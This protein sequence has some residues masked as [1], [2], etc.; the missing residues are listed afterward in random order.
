MA[1]RFLLCSAAAVIA[2]AL[3]C[4][5]SA[6][7]PASPSS[8]T[9][10]VSDAAADGSTLKATAPA[11]VSPIN[12]AQPETLELTANKSIGKFDSSVVLSYEFEIKNAGGTVVCNSGVI[13]GGT[14]ATVSY[15]PTCSLEFDAEHTWRA[16]AVYA[17][18][19][20]PWSA[21]ASF[22]TPTG[23]Y[24]NGNE[25]F[26]PL[27]NGKTVG[28]IRGPVQ[29]V[30]GVGAKLVGHESHILYRIPV[31]L[32]AG[33]FS[34][35]ILG[36]DEGTEGD[37]SKVFSMQEGPDENDITDDD[38]RFTAEL[39]G[40][41]YAQPGS[42]TYRIICGD[43]VSRDG[44]RNQLNFDSSRWYFWKFT[45]RTGSATL[46]VRRDSET[47]SV[48]YSST[49]GTGSHPYRPDPHYLYLGAPVGRAGLMDATLPGGT[50]KNVWASSRPRPSFPN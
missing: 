12:G 18:A 9:P 23:G 5:K 7:N 49:V 44:A 8:T 27:T 34:M 39:R 43:A 15:T 45:W 32:Q 16:R 35:M 14:G 50:Y 10:A 36:A 6:P 42:V 17:G 1:R 29:F 11:P 21:A 19:V 40:A 13:G 46:Q 20:G 2:V 48:I 3:A 26:D 22:K 30:A 38:Y 47:G 24:I 37:K 28:T 33:E 41:N 25:V 31:N 4:S